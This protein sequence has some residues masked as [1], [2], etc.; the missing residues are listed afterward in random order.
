MG[1]Y[2]WKRAMSAAPHFVSDTLS[3]SNDHLCQ[4]DEHFVRLI[5]VVK[6]FGDT[7]AVH[8]LDL[9]VAKSEIFA[10][11]GSSGCGKSTLMRMLAGLEPMTS[12]QIFIDGQDISTLPPYRRPVNM[13]FQSYALFPHMN[14]VNNIAFG[15]RQEGISRHEREHRVHEALELVQMAHLAK[16]MPAQLSGGQQQRVALARSL[17]KRPKLLL[18]DEP[19]S[20]LDRQIRQRTQF[21]LIDILQKVGVTC[22]IVTHDQDEAM[23]MAHRMAVMDEGEI[24]QIGSPSDIYR[25]PNC[26]FVAKFIG[27]TNIFEGNVTEDKADHVVV[28]TPEISHPLFIAH[29]ITGFMG[30]PIAVSIRPENI[31]LEPMVDD[32]DEPYNW[33]V[34]IIVNIAYMGAYNNYH[35]KTATGKTIIAQVP[36][37]YLDAMPALGES[38]LLK[39]SATAGVALAA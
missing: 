12:G 31:R 2:A 23:T 20:A 39:W 37:R 16:R 11:L 6:R 26:Q 29:G 33:T 4:T 36:G 19:M 17:V 10:L 24:L 18:L 27:I 35:V 32:F 15:L 28:A 13:M 14:V 25:Y 21:E 9:S 5:N 8:H 30:M 3:A 7:T 1:F 34:G 38:A 22:M